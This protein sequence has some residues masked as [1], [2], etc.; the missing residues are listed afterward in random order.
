MDPKVAWYRLVEWLGVLGMQTGP[1]E[2]LVTRSS[3]A[4]DGKNTVL[5]HCDL[6]FQIGAGQGLVATKRIQVC[7]ISICRAVT[8]RTGSHLHPS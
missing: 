7:A 4:G 5:F 6:Q 1:Q 3:I 8:D 2:L